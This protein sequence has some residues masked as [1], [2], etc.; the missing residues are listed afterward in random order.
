MSNQKKSNKLSCFLVFL[1]LIVVIAG[2]GYL[3]FSNWYNN[4]IYNPVSTSDEKV[5][6]TVSDGETF[7][8]L[9]P[10][11]KRLGLISSEEAIKV[12]LKLNNLS[13]NIKAGEFSVAKNLNVIDLIKALESNTLKES[14]L[15]TIPEGLKNQEVINLLK[16]KF[17]VVANSNFDANQFS[18][19]VNNPDS[20]EFEES[21]QIF[22]D[23]T[24]PAG[25]DLYG[26]LF[27]DTYNFDTDSTAQKVLETLILNLETRLVENGID[28]NNVGITQSQITNLYDALTLASIIE[29]EAGHDSDRPLVSGVFHNR[30]AENYP[31]QSD[32]TIHF[33]KGDDD[34]YISFDD[35]KI[36]SPYNTYL[37]A[38]LTPTPINNP[39]I[40]SIKA[41]IEPEET[42]YFFFIYDTSGKV[43]Y[44]VTYDQH[45]Q[46][47]YN[48]IQ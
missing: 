44:A 22:L 17:N 13:P 25:K 3:Y 10:E 18:D 46:N 47:I 5:R 33:L 6:L 24:K 32:I 38:G 41:A 23:K 34:P 26:F 1:L 4:A 21:V 20:F 31:L 2:G 43:Y 12:Y 45:Q 30:L 27:P 29:K 15:I 35:T 9:L 36:E 39:G 42:D 48:Y 7:Q 40:T 11:L 19:M 37:Y 16:E 28:Y 14:I 8:N